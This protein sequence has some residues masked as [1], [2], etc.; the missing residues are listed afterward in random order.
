MGTTSLR[1]GRDCK[2]GDHHGDA[3]ETLHGTILRPF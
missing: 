1:T 2:T 3:S